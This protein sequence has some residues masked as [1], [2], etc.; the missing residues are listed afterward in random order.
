MFRVRA[1]V[2]FFIA[3][4]VFFFYP[5]VFYPVA[6]RLMSLPTGTLMDYFSIV[7]L[8]LTMVIIFEIG[9]NQ[10]QSRRLNTI[11]SIRTRSDE[12]NEKP[13]PTAAK[14]E[15]VY[16]APA[17]VY[18]APKPAPS[19]PVIPAPAPAEPVKPEES[20]KPEPEWTGVP[21]DD[22]EEN[23]PEGGAFVNL[24]PEDASED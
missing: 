20:W 22:A 24:T 6:H 17:P 15:P 2:F 13:L 7:A 23:R 4:L 21:A 5:I 18:E 10:G 11:L 9:N 12:L 19:A 8:V 3:G 14:P 1:G 16:I